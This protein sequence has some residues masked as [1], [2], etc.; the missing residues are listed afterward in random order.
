MAFTA[1]TNLIRSTKRAV[2][3]AC[4]STAQ[5]V[6]TRRDRSGSASVISRGINPFVHVVHWG[7]DGRAPLPAAGPSNNVKPDLASASLCTDAC[8]CAAQHHLL[9]IK[10]AVL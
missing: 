4:A 1:S 8:K 9:E 2:P 7:E 3:R 5:S 10:T 6:T